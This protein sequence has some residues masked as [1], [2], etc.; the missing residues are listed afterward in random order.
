[1]TT[2]IK[3]FSIIC[4]SF[5][6]LDGRNLFLPGQFFP[7]CG[8]NLPILTAG[9]IT[10]IYIHTRRLSAK[11][12]ISTL[13][14]NFAI[15]RVLCCM[16]LCNRF[17]QSIAWHE[18]HFSAK[19]FYPRHYQLDGSTK[20]F[21]LCHYTLDGSTK[22]FYLRHYQLDGSTTSLVTKFVSFSHFNLMYI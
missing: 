19:F 11:Q 8:R 9:H 3:V 15:N 12:V 5:I 2:Q 14:I 4:V 1:M 20:P 10:Y 13:C 21:Y 18:M 16:F 7:P 17:H 22:P 6:F